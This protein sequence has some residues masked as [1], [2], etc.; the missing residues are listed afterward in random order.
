MTEPSRKSR[1]GLQPQQISSVAAVH[2]LLTPRQ[3]VASDALTVFCTG[4]SRPAEVSFEEFEKG[5]H[6]D[7][8]E[9]HHMWAG[10]FSGR[11][12]LIRELFPHLKILVES[13]S[14]VSVKGT[15]SDLRSWWRLLDTCHPVL[16]VKKPEDIGDLHALLARQ[17]G[18]DKDQYNFMRRLLNAYRLAH[19]LPQLH[20]EHIPRSANNQT[21]LP[22]QR[23]IKALHD[24]VKRRVFAVMAAWPLADAL[25]GSGQDWSGMMDQ[26][27]EKQRWLEADVHATFRSTLTR[28]KKPCASVLEIRGLIKSPRWV[29]DRLAEL[30]QSL[31]PSKVNVHDFLCLFVIRTG[32]NEGTAINIDV[33]NNDWI[34]INPLSPT[35]HTVRAIKPRGGMWQSCIGLEK[36]DISPGNLIRTLLKRTEPLRNQL[37]MNLQVLMEQRKAALEDPIQATDTTL[38]RSL[39]TQIGKLNQMIRSPWIFASGG[40]IGCLDG[41]N[42][43]SG[44]YTSIGKKGKRYMPS[45]IDEA[46]RRQ[47]ANDQIPATFVASDF[48]DGWISFSYKISGYNW[49]VA[50]LA[51]GH[52]SFETLK[53]YLRKRQWRAHSAKQVIGF[54][55]HMWTE[56]IVHKRVEPAVLKGLV[57]RGEVSDLQVRRWLDHKD[58]TRLGMG[59]KNNKSPPAYIDPHHINGNGCRTSRCTLCHLGIVFDHSMHLIARRYAELLHIKSSIPLSAWHESDFEIELEATQRALNG[60]DSAMVEKSVAY[61]LKEIDEGR[62]VPFSFAG[63]YSI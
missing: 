16:P 55:N 50:S 41:G 51:A 9:K 53:N 18:F 45:L 49:L 48:R 36:T 35:I 33:S 5:T 11:P 4:G 44:H 61:W 25:A 54:G 30:T 7:E 62:H 10:D 40:A 6:D 14:P 60:F 3:R 23:H 58:M 31:Y 42:D 17:A 47:P 19:G 22:E 52:K 12:D 2:N 59:C 37:K 26:R 8:T 1:K 46:N 43:L 13:K 29:A 63:T 27:I 38:V 28:L 24:V 32:W 15:V 21:S 39:D 34:S 56:I 20:W 57:E